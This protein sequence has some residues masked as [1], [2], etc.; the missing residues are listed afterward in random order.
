MPVILRTRD[1]IYLWMTAPAGEALT[2][3]RPLPD[4]AYMS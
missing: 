1:E 3:Q 4:D 2:M